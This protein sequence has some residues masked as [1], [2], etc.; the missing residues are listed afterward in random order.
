MSLLVANLSRLRPPDER[1]RWECSGLDSLPLTSRDDR[2]GF[3][4]AL[5]SDRLSD[6]RRS[7]LGYRR[8]LGARDDTRRW[9]REEAALFEYAQLGGVMVLF[10]TILISSYWFVVFAPTRREEER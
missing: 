10:V 1:N 6:P 4:F 3:K 7:A 2:A 8:I 9:L 5:G